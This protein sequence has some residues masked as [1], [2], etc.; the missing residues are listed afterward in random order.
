MR[1]FGRGF[2]E[3]IAEFD[4]NVLQLSGRGPAF[5]SRIRVAFGLGVHY[6][7]NTEFTRLS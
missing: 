3:K 7:N 5:R 1:L 2:V 4:V 6:D